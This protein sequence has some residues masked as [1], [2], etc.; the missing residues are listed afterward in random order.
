MCQLET[1][2]TRV[3]PAVSRPARYLGNEYNS[4]RKD[5]AE[6][7]LK[8]ALA[9]PDVYDVGMGHLGLKIL[10]HIINQREDALA[11]RVFA[12]WTD[13]EEELVQRGLPLFS[14]ESCR[15]L[16]DFHLSGLPSSMSLASNIFEHAPS[17]GIPWPGIDDSHPIIIAG[18]RALQSRAPG[19]LHRSVRRH[20]RGEFLIDELI[21]LALGLLQR[22]GAP[23]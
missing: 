11:E 23:G 15:P 4:I 20:R 18:G 22:P 7:P 16:G 3:L 13:M 9:F 21:D 5:W 8:M 17:C 10:Y 2:C 6:V 12:P 19:G 1:D 14:L